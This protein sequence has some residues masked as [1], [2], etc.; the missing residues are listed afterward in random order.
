MYH[1]AVIRLAIK[2]KVKVV[3]TSYVS[4]EINVEGAA[5]KAGVVV[6]NK[7]VVDP[8]VDHLYAIKKI[9]EVHAQG[10]KVS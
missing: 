10:G 3:S 6:L 1:L 2:N 9:G 7:V 8:G 5:Q 4:S